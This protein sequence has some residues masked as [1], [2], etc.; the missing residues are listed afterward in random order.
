MSP[1]DTPGAWRGRS[2]G[3]GRGRARRELSAAHLELLGAEPDAGRDQLQRPLDPVLL[4]LLGDRLGLRQQDLRG[5]V[6]ECADPLG[7]VA[8]RLVLGSV[9]EL[10]DAVHQGARGSLDGVSPIRCSSASILVESSLSWRPC[11]ER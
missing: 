4:D 1:A 8:D 10:F 3:S 9:F 5:A 11:T 7:L 2:A 6:D